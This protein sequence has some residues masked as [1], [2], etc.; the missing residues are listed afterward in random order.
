MPI[1]TVAIIV[2]AGAG[3]RM[4]GD[5]PK[6]LMP[7]GGR[8]MLLWSLAAL[9][10]SPLVD[11]VVVVGPAARLESMRALVGAGPG[12]RVVAGGASRQ[13][14]V[15]EGLR[16]AP[17]GAARVLV[18]HPPP[19]RI[20]QALEAAVLGGREGVA[21][22]LAAAPVVDTLKRADDE[23]C[24]GGTVPREGLWAAQTPQAFRAAALREATE[25]AAAEGRLAAAT[26]CASVVE[27]WG[28]RVRLVAATGPN[29][30]V[31]TPADV[32]VAQT[33]RARR[34]PG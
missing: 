8:P 2:A 12:V 25:A 5:V 6:A 31:T 27:A 32:A 18:H 30:K 28:G 16:A 4:G 33:L 22:A 24:V 29:P 7:L 9:R 11:R 19:P 23:G 14:S 13:E 1:S 17:A 34:A 20:D 15:R 21:G 3:V 26:D 10:A